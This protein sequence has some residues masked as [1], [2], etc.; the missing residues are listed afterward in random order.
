MAPPYMPHGCHNREFIANIGNIAYSCTK[1]EGIIERPTLYTNTEEA[2]ER[3]WLHCVYSGASKI[4]IFSPD[5]DT[6]HVGLAHLEKMP[7]KDIIVQLSS[8]STSNGGRT[9]FLH[10]NAPLEGLSRDSDLGD[11]PLNDK[12]YNLYMLLQDVIMCHILLALENAPS[13]QL[14]T[15]MQG[16]LREVNH[17]IQLA[18]LEKLYMKALFTHF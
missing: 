18:Q 11:I 1:S 9:K 4:L 7:Q 10:L 13:C 3:I 2:D 14:S 12:C 6:C 15:S 8:S 16:S 17:Q 5:T